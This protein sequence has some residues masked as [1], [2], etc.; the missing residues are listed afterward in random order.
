MNNGLIFFMNSEYQTPHPD[1][2][3]LH[4]FYHSTEIANSGVTYQKPG[5][6]LYVKSEEKLKINT[7]NIDSLNQ[8]C[9]LSHHR[10]EV[11]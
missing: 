11:Y 10:E 7:T 4:V 9:V 6:Y 8:V 1:P 3:I 5:T 2:H